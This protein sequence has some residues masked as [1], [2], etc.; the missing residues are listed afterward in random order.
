MPARLIVMVASLLCLSAPSINAAQARLTT[1]D[2]IGTVN[3]PT[4]ARIAGA[5][6]TVTN[7]DTN[8][9][10]AVTTD[11][12][13]RYSAPALPPGAYTL[14]AS[15][16]G[17]RTQVRERIDLLLGQTVTI[18]FELTVVTQENVTVTANAPLVA[19]GRTEV[20]TVLTQ[21]QIEQL[22][23]NGRNFVAFAVITPGV[24]TDKT[25]MQ[26]ASATS[27]LSFNGQR[28]RSNNIMVD[29]L[30][31]NDP[32]VGAVRATFS[33]EAV[34]EFQVLTNSYSAEFG[35]AAGG[36]LNIVTKS[37]TNTFHGNTFFYLR[38]QTLNAR[39]YFDKFDIFGNPAALEKP[40]FSQ[41]QWGATLGGPVERSRTFFFA[42]YE[43]LSLEDARLVTIDPAAATLLNRLGFPVEIGNVP[44]Q[45]SNSEVFGKIDHQWTSAR[46]LTTRGSYA[47][48]D[49]EG[50]DDF[51][52]IVARSRGTT[53]LRTNWSLSAAESDVWSPRWINELRAQFAYENQQVNA[54]DPLCGGPC[55]EVDQG[56]PTLDLIGVA[57][58]GRQR[59][60]PQRRLTRRLQLLETVSAFSG[61]H[62][63]KAGAEFNRVTAPSSGN[64]LPGFFGGR[65]IFTAIPALGVASS[66]DAL[67]RG[68]PAA[69]IQGYGNP[70]V[71]AFPYR[72]LALFAQDEWRRD[73]IVVKPGIRYQRQFWNSFTHRVSD[74]DGGI[75]TY[76]PPT[77]ANDIAPR[78]GVAYDLTGRGR[79][80]V[81]GSYGL[82][83]DHTIVGVQTIGQ[84]LN[85][86][87]GVR[88]LVLPAPLASV[89]WN[90]SGHRLSELQAAALLG[91]S[92]ASAVLPPDPSLKDAFTHQASAG[93]D[94]AIGLDA[95]LAV[96]VVLVRGF[97]IPGTIDYNPTLPARLGPGRRPNDLPCAV[98]PGAPC[99]NGGIPGTSASV[100]QYT[101]FGESWYRGLSV[102]LNKRLN[103]DY[104]FLLSY[105][106][107]KAE[108]T[109][110]DY[111][112]NFIPQNNGYGR[113]PADKLGLP[114]GFEPDSE[115]GPSTH[116]Q[117]HRFVLSGVSQLPGRMQLSGIVTLA[118]GRPFTPLVGVDLNG[119]G[120]GGGFPTDRARRDPASESTSVGRNSKTT[121]AQA[122]VDL[123]LSR[124]F[125][126]GERGAFEAI[127]E[128][129]NLFNRTNF[130]EDSNQSSFVVFGA[131][132]YPT[133]PLPAYGRYTLTLPPRQLQ[134]AAKI[135]F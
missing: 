19:T 100:L 110:T 115:R 126:L 59:T 117:R 6:I 92:Y 50:I 13:G 10:R 62:H 120:N 112:A 119:D 132:A 106:L 47:N 116:D 43:G 11:A 65:Y 85:G 125:R 21:G 123:R 66:I 109:S 94:Q 49:R 113:N 29:G 108:D 87:D 67:E 24:S 72:D 107:S 57:S 134:L 1:A 130:I 9:M 20:S 118:S 135:S 42:S 81:H 37:G 32:A 14:T 76:L 48:I 124:R 70:D 35:K 69:Y 74:V 12:V 101:A 121:A 28:A 89:A 77:D 54:L 103:R 3:D 30:D 73:R 97:N 71:P 127:L 131:G 68:I 64:V 18:D 36:V 23:V 7:V 58:V 38:D 111:L 63:F 25:P 98:R 39:N 53:Q 99:V 86:G 2:I 22:P 40:P 60:T 122:S 129:F 91:G 61:A 55:V 79:S 45:V 128:A 51:G 41:K 82:F 5:T 44:L 84:V 133:N 95:A 102:A 80:I 33:Q 83:F 114:L 90:A 31:N 52:G 15:L 75:L 88:T 78:I 4:G 16:P 56:G 8:V 46:T 34:R 104:E 105:T 93:L 17:F 96:N 26:G 27:G